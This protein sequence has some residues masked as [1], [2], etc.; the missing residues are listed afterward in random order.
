MDSILERLQLKRLRLNWCLLINSPDYNWMADQKVYYTYQKFKK[1]T[2]ERRWLTKL[3]VLMD[4]REWESC[5]KGILKFYQVQ[6][7][8]LLEVRRKELLN[9]TLSNL[10]LIV[11]SVDVQDNTSFELQNASKYKSILKTLDQNQPEIIC[12]YNFAY[13]QEF[14]R[15]DKILRWKHF[16]RD[17]GAQQIAVSFNDEVALFRAYEIL[18][19]FKGI[20]Y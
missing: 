13:A 2:E 10:Y 8:Q 16:Q 4:S 5:G 1:L 17:Q 6:N 7:Q 19:E 9:K 3:Y 14:S 12:F 15:E 18:C 11:D 20:P